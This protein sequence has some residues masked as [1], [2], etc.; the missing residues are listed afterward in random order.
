MS[1]NVSALVQL[2]TALQQQ[3][4]GQTAFDRNKAFLLPGNHTYNTQL[5][6][7]QEQQF[8][9]WVTQNKVPFDP[10]AGVTDYDMRGFWQALQAKDPRA[11]SAIDPND[12]RLHYPDYW[13]TPYHETFSAQSQWADPTKAP[14][15]NAQDQLVMPNGQV[16][17]DDRRQNAPF[18]LSPTPNPLTFP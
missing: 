18:S 9:N 15:W 17:Y 13:K 1:D 16:I 4:P 11:T 10:S 6:P 3:Q 12:Q 8:S 14:N 7:Q 5:S 2:L